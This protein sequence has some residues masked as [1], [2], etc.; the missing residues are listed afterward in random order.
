MSLE[1]MQAAGKLAGEV[2]TFIEPHVVPGI[3]TDELNTL[4][5]N[6]IVDH[7]AIPA[8]LNY[9]GFPKSICTSVNEVVCHGI[10]GPYKLKSGDIINIDV[11]VILDG[12]YGD[13]SKTFLVGQCTNF[14]K[15]L[16]D[17]AREALEVGIKAVRPYG[18]FG[19]IGAAIEKFVKPTGFSIVRDYGGHGI[20]TFFHGDPFVAHY[21]TK[22]QGP[23]IL[24]GSFFTIEPMINAGKYKCKTLKDNWTVVT[25]DHSLSAQFE[26]TVAITQSETIIT[27]SV[28]L[29]RPPCPRPADAS[30]GVRCPDSIRFQA[31]RLRCHLNR[32]CPNPLNF[33]FGTL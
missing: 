22:E 5:H 21:D 19:E 2:L 4:C 15:E 18:Y 32:C 7:N 10:P 14:A 8:P 29:D 23:K 6:F 16:V 12:F 13:T 9:N 28:P 17:V 31:L 3:T 33:V 30:S 27:T 11:T 24:P 1:K 26:H 25:S 20:G